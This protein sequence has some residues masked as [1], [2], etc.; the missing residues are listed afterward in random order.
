MCE[1]ASPTN[2]SIDSACVDRIIHRFNYVF[3]V[4]AKALKIDGRWVLYGL[5]GGASAGQL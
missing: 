2:D 5:M 4:R 1:R 3:L